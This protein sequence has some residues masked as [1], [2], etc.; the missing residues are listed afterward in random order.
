MARF[1][2]ERVVPAP[3]AEVFDVSLDVG[4]H[5]RSQASHGERVAAGPTSGIL[6][7]GDGIT[8]SARHFGIRFEMASIVFDV[9]RPHR[10]RDRQTRGPFARFE[11]THE[12]ESRPDGTLMR[13]TIVFRSPFWLLGRAVDALFMRRHLIGVISERNDTISAHLAG[14]R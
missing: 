5:L 13:D 3:P 7:E 1:V 8:W 2:L 14:A 12:F 6:G 4:L 11:H 10:F 9:D